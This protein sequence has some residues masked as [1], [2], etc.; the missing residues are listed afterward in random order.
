MFDAVVHVDIAEIEPIRP[1]TAAENAR[2]EIWHEEAESR[3]EVVGVAHGI[4][5]LAERDISTIVRKD[6]CG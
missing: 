6:A 2:H 1:V 4:A 5:E 3:G